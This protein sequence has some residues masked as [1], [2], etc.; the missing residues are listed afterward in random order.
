MFNFSS[1]DQ[2][3]IC[4]S[5]GNYKLDAFVASGSNVSIY[6]AKSSNCNSAPQVAVK[7]AR[8]IPSHLAL[9][10][11]III[12]IIIRFREKSLWRTF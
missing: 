11:E 12:E 4:E 1:D 9:N 10:N 8:T 6:T 2:F 5:I 7:L 3:V